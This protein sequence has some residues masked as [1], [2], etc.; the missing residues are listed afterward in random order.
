M[1]KWKEIGEPFNKGKHLYVQC[2]CVCGTVKDVNLRD[3]R[4]GKTKGC[5]KC[6][7][8]DGVKTHGMSGTPEYK[9]W[10]R[11]KIRCYSQSYHEYHYYGGRGIT[12]CD[13]WLES[14]ENFIEDMGQRPSINHSL[15]RIN[16]NEGYNKE[17]CRWADKTTQSFNKRKRKDNTS[18]VVGV[19]KVPYGYIA[20]ISKNNQ[21]HYLGFFEEMEDVILCRKDAELKYYSI[22]EEHNQ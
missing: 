4:L 18:G 8:N 21:Q 11:M 3:L 7:N 17:N 12:V 2:V 13:R 6:R 1:I 5:I 9:A 16:V 10:A 22:I 20:S 15:D 19:Y 14:F